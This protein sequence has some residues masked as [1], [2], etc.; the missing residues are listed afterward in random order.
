MKN[1][2]FILIL[3][4][5]FMVNCSR[6]REIREASS[7]SKSPDRIMLSIP[8]D[9]SNSRAVT[10]RTSTLAE[11]SIGQI[12][13]GT[14]SPFF[15]DQILDFTGIS[16]FWMEGDTSSLGHKVIFENLVPETMYLYRVGDGENW[17]EWFQFT[18]SSNENKPFN[19]I[20]LG[21]FQNNIKEYCSRVI[22]QAY[23]HF[24]NA[25]F[26]LFAGDLVS[27]STESYWSEFFYAGNWIF[28]TMPS[29]ATPG[30]HE[31][32]KNGNSNSRIFSKHWNQIFVATANGPENLGNRTYFFD[33]QGVR[34]VS[35]DS[36]AMGYAKENLDNTVEWLNNV[37]SD[38]PNQWTILFTHYPVYSCSQGR[39]DEE[40]REIL[41]PILEKY[42]VDLVLQGHD[43]TYCRGQNLDNIGIECKN[44]PMYMVSVSG[45]KMYGL[46]VDKWSDRVASE[47]QLYQ[48]VEI[49]G[50]SIKVGTFTVTGELYDSFLLIK[51][52]NGINKV[53]E[54]EIVQNIEENIKIPE[55]AKKNY[56][57]EEL[58]QYEERYQKN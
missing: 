41:K 28:G 5:I 15:E 42:G 6:E 9:P 46:N 39:N 26:I 54:K 44:P 53:V 37:L 45:P 17:S 3:F 11:K 22:R 12:T 27:E 55:G 18:T 31:Y 23:S 51:G 58:K 40:Y 16:S 14:S 43:H 33:Y 47:T 7:A 50:D 30:N 21:D 24:P 56:S 20:Y 29:V 49:N 25:G 38:N 52:K 35:V 2:Y 57:E 32:S 1:Q 36:P 10:W 34:F 4:A 48:N 19:F 8:G 13:K